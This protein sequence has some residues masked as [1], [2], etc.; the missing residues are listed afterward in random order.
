MPINYDEFTD[1]E[2]VD[3]YHEGESDVANYLIKKYQNLIQA[4]ANNMFIIGGDFDDV[5]QEGRIGL[6]RAIEKFDPG[7]DAVFTTFA[8]LCISRSIY[9]A[10]D[11]ANRQYNK[12]LNQYISIYIDESKAEN[13]ESSG[14]DNIA[15]Q[16]SDELKEK[17][18]P[19]RIVIDDEKLSDL[20][21]YINKELSE[22][23]KQIVELKVAGYDYKE[24]AAILGKTEKS[25]D[26][27]QQ[28]LKNKIKKYL[29]G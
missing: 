24:I 6:F 18:N 10:I 27:G 29:E 19:E 1:E 25:I 7:R 22:F 23:E 9:S 16:I 20:E 15:H 13:D 8:N 26:N 3:M 2:L 28:R 4:N 17:H 11:K 21:R 14:E 12:F 5:L